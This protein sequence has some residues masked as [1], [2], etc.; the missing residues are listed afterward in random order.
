MI[1]CSPKAASRLRCKLLNDT[2]VEA[3]KG[4]RIGVRATGCSGLSYVLEVCD[5]ANVGTDDE[6]FESEGVSLV[7]S[8]KD[9]S[10][11]G[12]TRLDYE[13][14]GFSERFTFANPNEV[15]RCGCGESFKV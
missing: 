7:M 3:P 12:G 1:S 2:S 11:L 6:V 15:A 5:L 13:R 10:F 9:Q 4:L 14:D 8:R